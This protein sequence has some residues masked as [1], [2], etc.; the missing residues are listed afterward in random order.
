MK[1]LHALFLAGLAC[2][3]LARAE[4]VD[5]NTAGV[6]ELA[7]AIKGVSDA[8]AKAIVEYRTEHGPF[9]SVDDIVLVPG[10]GTR[11]LENNR[12]VLSVGKP[13]AAAAT[14]QK[15]KAG[16]AAGTKAKA[17]PQAGL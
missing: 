14:S 6:A 13:A 12:D 2:S 7:D 17:S 8:R 15:D 10:I 5:I 11:I 16:D 1:F 9:Q 4:V 3:G